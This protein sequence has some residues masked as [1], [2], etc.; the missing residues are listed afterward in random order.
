MAQ[1]SLP[2]AAIFIAPFILLI[3]CIKLQSLQLVIFI[4]IARQVV[5]VVDL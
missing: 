3:I 4:L 1:T 2:S 5:V